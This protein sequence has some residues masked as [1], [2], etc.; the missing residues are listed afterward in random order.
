ML[1]AQI[2]TFNKYKNLIVYL[3]KNQISLKYRKS[4]LGLIWSL[5]NPLLTM[6]VLT[7]IF[8]SIFKNQIENFPIYLM[9]GRLIYEYNAE[10][11]KTAMDSIV[12]NSSLLKKIYIPKYVFPL[13]NSVAALVNMAFS[14][15]ALVIVMLFTQVQLKWTMLLFWLP[16]LYVFVFSTGLG[17]ILATINVFFRDMKHLYSVVLTLWMYMT[18]LFYPIE[19]V[20]STVQKIIML[21]PLYYYVKMM[22]GLIL[23]GTLPSLSDNLLCAGIGIAAILIGV[24]VFKKKQDKFILYI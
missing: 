18:P 14:L 5:L 6:L 3:A 24:F 10:S 23:D 15:I 17:L 21:N 12:S 8:S 4:Y 1:K 7:M 9:C 22:R 13:S 16:M 11:T 2:E 20:G 19:A